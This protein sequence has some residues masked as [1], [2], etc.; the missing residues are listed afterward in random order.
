MK[1]MVERE[2]IVRCMKHI[3]NKYLSDCESEDLL[4]AVVAH[5]LNCLFAPKDFIKK[6]DEGTIKCKP[7]TI[8]EVADIDLLE[9]IEKLEAPEKVEEDLEKQN[10]SK[11]EKKRQ[12]IAAKQGDEKVEAKVEVK[13]TTVDNMSDLMF[14]AQSDFMT[15]DSSELFKEPEVALGVVES[16]IMEVFEMTP[17]QLYIEIRKLAEQRYKYTLLPKKHHQLKVLDSQNNKFS[18]LRDICKCTGITL[19]FSSDNQYI[20]ENDGEKMRQ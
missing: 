19:D 9:N 20:L 6:L 11:K 5:L 12:K 1:F 14:K 2:I 7:Q 8:K 18:V 10:L 17:K 16:Q 15:F 3:V 13:K 4:S